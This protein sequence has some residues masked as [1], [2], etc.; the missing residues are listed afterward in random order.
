M[1]HKKR[2][3]IAS[4]AFA[5]LSAHLP[6]NAQELRVPLG[7]QGNSSTVVPKRGIS[8]DL[9]KQQF[10]EPYD[11]VEN[12]GEPP[13]STWYYHD[14]NVYFESDKVIHSVIKQQN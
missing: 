2:L 7:Q 6:L 4:I 9:V 5:L 1:K 14:F 12:I 10:G 11:A 13:I 3:I 8:Q